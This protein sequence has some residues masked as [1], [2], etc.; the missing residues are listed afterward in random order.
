MKATF[1]FIS[2][3]ICICL[4]TCLS[5]CR[6]NSSSFR[7]FNTFVYIDTYGQTFSK[8]QEKEIQNTLISLENTF[9]ATKEGSFL[10]KI[11]GAKN[12]QVINAN[13]FER[14]IFA[15]ATEFYTF[16]QGKFNPAVYPLLKLWG[17][18]PKYPVLNFTPPTDQALLSASSYTDFSMVSLTQNGVTKT[19]DNLQIDFGGFLK[20]YATDLVGKALSSSGITKGYVSMGG[21]SLYLLSVESVSVNH[22][23]K[24]GESILSVVGSSLNNYSVSTSGTYE[25]F[26]TIDGV[27]YS[28]IIDAST[29]KPSQKNI[30]SATIICKDGAFADAMT[31]ALCLCDFNPI[32]PTAN[33]LVDFIN[34]IVERYQEAQIFVVYNNGEHK[35]IITNANS[36]AF[37]LL[38]LEYTPVYI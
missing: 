24:S 22:P 15:L 25:R 11:N 5:A 37:S 19:I 18:A 28:H 3:F 38:D 4:L 9:S 21:S 36:Q 34:D 17:F 12:G 33:Q 13:A 6:I 10:S 32:S 23:E 14:E 8:T 1:K 26:Y 2:L 35:N 16:S 30:L 7:A 29:G 20:G 27:N 31:T